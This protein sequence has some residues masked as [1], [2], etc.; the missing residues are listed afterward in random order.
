MGVK[1]K[2][3]QQNAALSALPIAVPTGMTGAKTHD[4]RP[5]E[6]WGLARP[7]SISEG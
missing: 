1:A 7:K 6:T 4:R 3:K 5:A 2:K